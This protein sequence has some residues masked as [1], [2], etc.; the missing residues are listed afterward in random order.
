MTTPV[1]EDL[2]TVFILF[3]FALIVLLI[4]YVLVRQLII[5]DVFLVGEGLVLP[6][7]RFDYRPSSRASH[8]LR[9]IPGF[10]YVDY[11]WS[12]RSHR[13]VSSTFVLLRGYLNLFAWTR[14]LLN[15]ITSSILNDLLIFMKSALFRRF[16]L[17]QLSF[18]HGSIPKLYYFVL[19]IVLGIVTKPCR[20]FEPPLQHYLPLWKSE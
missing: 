3:L 19:G 12:S 6:F 1:I 15:S 17:E 4:T 16:A 14:L 8:G 9:D 5:G 2:T 18:H 11:Y 7:Q 10:K 20:S 13:N